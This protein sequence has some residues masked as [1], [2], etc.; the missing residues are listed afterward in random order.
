MLSAIKHIYT[1][2]KG[3]I[4]SLCFIHSS[5]TCQ[6]QYFRTLD[7]HVL[8]EGGVYL[9]CRLIIKTSLISLV[10]G[11]GQCVLLGTKTGKCLK[12]QS[13][14]EQSEGPEFYLHFGLIHFTVISRII[15]KMW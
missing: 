5:F 11:D 3:V 14:L 10:K 13:F 15:S 2:L 9:I 8:V 7:F 1:F 4:C 12:T 6:L